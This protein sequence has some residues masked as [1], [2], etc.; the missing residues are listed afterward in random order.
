MGD[1]KQGRGKAPKT[2]R[3]FTERYPDIGAAWELLRKAESTGGLDE[4]TLRLVK[5]GIAIGGMKEGAVHS[6]VRKALAAGVTTGEVE[7]VVAMAASTIG[8]P[9]TVA[10]YSWV[11]EQVEKRDD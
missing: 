2:Y 9:S 11:L 7:Q 4:R 3:S 10:I 1:A 6:A 5:L 8:L